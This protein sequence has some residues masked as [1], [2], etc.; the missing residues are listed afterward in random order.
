[1][2]FQCLHQL[3][4]F[5]CVISLLINLYS[6]REGYPR[7]ASPFSGMTVTSGVAVIVR[8]KY[9]LH[10]HILH[11]HLSHLSRTFNFHPFGHELSSTFEDMDF[12]VN[13]TS[14]CFRSEAVIVTKLY[15]MVIVN[16]IIF[17]P[18]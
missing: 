13:G 8:D 14:L 10:I 1:M 9:E 4:P 17:A 12:H 3:A 5:Y 18:P 7:V 6:F 16:N 11:L 2:G 15:Q